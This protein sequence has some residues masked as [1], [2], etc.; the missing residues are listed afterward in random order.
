MIKIFRTHHFP[1]R[2]SLSLDVDECGD[3]NVTC[4]DGKYCSNNPGS[5]ACLECDKAC[6]QCTSSGTEKC[7]ACNSGF[8]LTNN[9]CEGKRDLIPKFCLC[10]FVS[11]KI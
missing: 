3:G 6:S 11:M 8:E 5:Y 1:F 2:L 7:S 4:E 10:C 9:G